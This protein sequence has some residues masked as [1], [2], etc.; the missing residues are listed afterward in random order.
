MEQRKWR[1][2]SPESAALMDKLDAE[3]EALWGPV[4]EADVDK[5]R[6]ALAT[7]QRAWCGALVHSAGRSEQ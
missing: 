3:C 2:L 1:H 5:V 4:T 7:A 6:E